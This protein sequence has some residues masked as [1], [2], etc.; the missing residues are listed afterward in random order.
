MQPRLRR[1]MLLTAAL[2]GVAAGAQAPPLI[3]SAVLDTSDTP[4]TLTLLGTG[5]APTGG[6]PRVLFDNT[7]LTLQSYGNTNIVANMPA[8][9]SPYPPGT[10]DVLITAGTVTSSPFG[11]TV[12]GVGPAGPA[13]PT[14]PQGPP[15]PTGPQGPKGAKGAAGPAGPAGPAGLAWQSAWSST[16]TYQLNDAVS[17]VGNSY[18]SLTAGNTGN[19]PN[20]SPTAWSLLAKAGAQGATG[21]AGPQGPQGATGATG[22]Q[23]PA[24]PKGA[25]GATGAQGPAGAQGPTGPAGL[26]WQSAWS[27]T[28]TY[29]LHDAVSYSGNSY[30]SLIANN[31]GNQPNT[32]PTAWSLLAKAGAQGATGPAGPQGPQGA[33][34]ATGAQGPAGPQGATGASGAQG[35]VGPPG[36]VWRSGWNG[37]TSYNA[38]DA[39]VWN[40]SSYICLSANKGD[41]P[42]ISPGFWSLL[43]AMG[44]TGATGATGLQGPAGPQGP[45]GATGARGPT[46]PTGATG[47]QGTAGTNGTNGNTVLNGTTTPPPPN[48]GANG[49]F[50]LYTTTNC[51][52]GPKAAGAWPASCVSLVGP[53]GAMG[54]QGVAGPQGADG[55]QGIAGPQGAAGPQGIAGPQGPAG[56]P[57]IL[58]GFCG[59]STIGSLGAVTGV[60]LQLGSEDA[61]QPGCFNGLTPTAVIGLPMTS[62]GNLQNLTVASNANGNGGSP[63]TVSVY[64]NGIVTDIACTIAG[65][66]CADTANTAHVLAGDTVAVQLSASSAPL[67]QLSVHA[68]LE[69]Q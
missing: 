36:M 66:T 32:S 68:S 8:S 45:A 34:G 56:P 64:V 13:G 61:S 10:Y 11:I 19:K 47:P 21:P 18:I 43:A 57:V 6:I 59:T 33:T 22:A 26:V 60:L 38:N 25:T 46:G 16:K 3:Y 17:Y 4:N 44:A 49:D 35:P 54:P 52:F 1:L 55:P 65:S 7:L 51:L 14:G 58:S 31:T 63:I 2:A 28:A 20:T 67:G 62:D 39:V 53:Q 42:D 23:G 48:T 30:V 15:G 37:N 41:Q 40:G 12:G 27:S 69:K 29:K 50:Y 24:G 5:F 9:P